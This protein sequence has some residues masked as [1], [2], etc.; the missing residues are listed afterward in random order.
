MLLT[1][2]LM[3]L[4]DRFKVVR[5]C[6]EGL[7]AFTN[8]FSL[9][10]LLP[11]SQH[12]LRE[13]LGILLGLADQLADACRRDSKLRGYLLVEVP[14]DDNAVDNTHLVGHRERGSP[15]ALLSATDGG[16]LLVLRG[17]YL[18]RVL[19]FAIASIQELVAQFCS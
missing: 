12:H 16:E 2:M 4:L 1:D 5:V 3:D 6:V 7:N 19:M 15:V 17:V 11:L 18:D 13:K 9:G 14:L 10:I 8:R